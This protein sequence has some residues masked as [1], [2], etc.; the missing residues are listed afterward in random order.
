MDSNECL[1]NILET[2]SNLLK[3]N[4]LYSDKSDKKELF[5]ALEYAD[6]L[7]EQITNLNDWISKGGFLPTQWRRPMV[8][9]VIGYPVGKDSQPLITSKYDTYLDA[10]RAR[11]MMMCSTTK[12]WKFEVVIQYPEAQETTS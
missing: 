9:K 4:F 5:A 2:A 6:Y 1:K 7:A 3:E 12:N 11:Q 8:Y 10:C